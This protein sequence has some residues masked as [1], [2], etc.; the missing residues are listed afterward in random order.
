MFKVMATGA[1]V[2]GTLG[3]GSDDTRLCFRGVVRVEVDVLVRMG[4]FSVDCGLD[5]LAGVS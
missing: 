1:N 3:E 5:P 4:V 2:L